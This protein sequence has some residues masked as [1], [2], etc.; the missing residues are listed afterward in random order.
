MRIQ[1]VFPAVLADGAQ[2][3][4]RAG[5]GPHD[6]Q[7]FL[8]RCE[9]II[10]IQNVLR[11]RAIALLQLL[12]GPAERVLGQPAQLVKGNLDSVLLRRAVIRPCNRIIS[13]KK[14]TIIIPYKVEKLHIH[15]AFPVRIF[16][17][18]Y[19]LFAFIL[20]CQDQFLAKIYHVLLFSV[21]FDVT[22]HP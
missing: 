10:C 18:I 6:L 2:R 1:I 9:G 22:I 5:I 16:C 14:R 11:R 13:I 8:L 3:L 19:H 4:A 17:I 12:C 20:V 21:K 7:C 15:F